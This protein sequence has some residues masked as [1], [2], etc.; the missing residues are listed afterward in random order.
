MSFTVYTLQKLYVLPVDGSLYLIINAKISN[1]LLLQGT[2]DSIH[3]N[4]KLNKAYQK[5]EVVTSKAKESE[6]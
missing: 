2:V 1:L 4:R 5:Q 6:Y 3:R